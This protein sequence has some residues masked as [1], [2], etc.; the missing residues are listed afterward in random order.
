M[1]SVYCPPDSFHPSLK[2]TKPAKWHLL[3]RL[4]GDRKCWFRAVAEGPVQHST[5]LQRCGQRETPIPYFLLEGVKLG[6]NQ[7]QSCF[8]VSNCPWFSPSVCFAQR[9]MESFL[10]HSRYWRGYVRV[11]GKG[12]TFPEPVCALTQENSILFTI[13]LLWCLL[14]VFKQM[15]MQL[16]QDI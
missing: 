3:H 14:F 4:L 7:S 10:A 8:R 11:W 5:Y 16:Y 15:L 12:P 6:G 1:S 2:N 9:T 13:A